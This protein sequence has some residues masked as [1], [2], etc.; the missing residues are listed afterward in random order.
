MI[1]H[2]Y[3]ETRRRTCKIN[4][5]S[6]VG[7]KPLVSQDGELMDC[8]RIHCTPLKTKIDLKTTYTTQLSF[9]LCIRK[10]N[11]HC[12]ACKDPISTLLFKDRPGFLPKK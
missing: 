1:D 2:F 8:I 7:G 6:C 12:S 5:C 3:D 10:N 4:N 9:R 11:N